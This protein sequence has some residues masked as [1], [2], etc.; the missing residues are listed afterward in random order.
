MVWVNDPERGMVISFNGT[1]ASGACVTTD[2]IIPAMTLENDFTW[3]FWAKQHTDQATD[4]STILG[5]RY[6]GTQSPLQFIK[7]TPTRF[8]RS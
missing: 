7:F 6:G 1:D 3:A 4:N 8:R 5:N 2:V